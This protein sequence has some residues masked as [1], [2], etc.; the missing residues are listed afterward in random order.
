MIK[1]NIKIYGWILL[2]SWLAVS[3]STTK[4]LPEEEVLYTGIKKIDYGQKPGTK[5]KTQEG[6]ITSIADAYKTVDELLTQ[7]NSSEREQAAAQTKAQQDS[8]AAVLR[9]EK[10]NYNTVKEEVDAALAYAPNNAFLGSSYYRLPLPT[11]LWIYN[12]LIGKK[13]RMAKWV[14]ETFGSTPIYI[15]TVNPKTR[16]FV[17]QNTLRNYGYFNGTVD[18]EIIPQKNPR[19]AKIS[20]T[21]NPRTL[22]RLD[23]IAYLRFPLEGDSLIRQTYKQRTLFKGDPFSV[24]N[25]DAERTR[26]YNMFRNSG[27]Y[28]YKPEYITFRADTLQRPGFVQLQV[29]PADGIPAAASRRYYLGRT[30]IQLYD[31]DATEELTDSLRIPNYTLYYKG[32]KNGKSPLRLGA[33]RRNLFYRKGMLY[34]QE[35]MSFVQQ[36]LSEMGV[37]SNVNMKYVP[38]DTTALNDTLDIHITGVLDKPYDGEFTTKVTSKSNGQIG[39]GLSFS[40]SKRNAFRG[41]EKLKFEVHGSYEWQTNS[42]VQ[43]SRSVI[44]SYEYGTS[45]SLDYP[46]LIFPGIKKFSRRAQTST[47]FVLDATWMNRANYF[48]MVSLS[49]RAAYTYQARPTIKHEFVPFRVDYDKLLSTTSVFDSIMNANQALY[50]S[51]RNQLVPSMRYTFTYSSPRKAHNPSTFIFEVKESG[52]ITS[53]IFAAFG[54]PFDRKDKKI[55]NVP[56]A[57]YMRFTAEYREEFRI[58]PRTSIATRIGSGVIISYGNSTAA[59]YNDL[60]SVGGANS[61]RAF[62]VRGVGP[63]HYIPGT[64]AYSYIDQMGDF[65]I[66]MNAEYRFPLI[67]L[68]S[69]AVF[70]DAG[71]VWLLKSDESRPG[72]TFDISRFGKDLA[73]GTGFGIRC[74]LDFLVLRF[75]IG[76]GL[77]T[78]YDT[79]KSGYYNM[80]KFKDSLGYHFA[81]GYPF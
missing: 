42:S 40:M 57:Q 62:T 3:C 43:G 50:V 76:V 7:K 46:S 41:A 80:P 54:Q 65:K 68:L 29:V 75:D 55:F 51:V 4:N 53:G 21:V 45:L 59:P 73:L 72:G 2:C 1:G 24:I 71:N 77:H 12:A 17:A 14:R 70:L 60:F 34:R 23:S 38:R 49:A 13:S 10:E 58:T 67:S 81:V 28:Y 66:E 15:S 18:Y 52:N 30:T 25:L 19:M 33:I 64:S 11:G 26:I 35:F 36:Q 8:I 32:G 16:A 22:F 74:D 39:P 5:S 47:S 69:G 48:G 6:V 79:G 20:Y 61:I 27:Y 31:N 37:F 63:G 78:P 56:F 9:I 44:N